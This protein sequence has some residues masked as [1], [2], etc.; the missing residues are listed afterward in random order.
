MTEA[1]F[2]SDEWLGQRLGKPA[3]HLSGKP[4][5]LPRE[6]WAKLG[7]SPL[8]ADAKIPV[9]DVEGAYVLTQAGFRLVDTL[10]TFDAPIGRLARGGARDT[11]G[12]V[13]DAEES[14]VADLAAIAFQQD[15][16]N[17][18]PNIPP[19]CAS[20]LKRDWASNFFRGQRGRWMVVA[21]KTEVGRGVGPDAG[22]VVGFLQLLYAPANTMIIDLIAVAPTH[23]GQGLGKAMIGYAVTHCPDVETVLVGTQAANVAAARLYETM[24]FRMASAQ[25]VFH[26]HGA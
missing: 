6:E 12:F 9:S 25:Y 20:R 1:G 7:Q 13:Q 16:F 24:G 2:V 22:K 23:T 21:R 11:V 26:Y 14:A 17:R 8:F 3:Y 5:E 10:L 4:G 15:R 19:D 18:D